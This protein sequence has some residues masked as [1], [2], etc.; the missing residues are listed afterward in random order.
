MSERILITGGAGFIGRIVGRELLDRGYE[1]RVLDSLIEQ[2][3]G[4]GERPEGLDD[5][6]LLVGD[7]CDASC[8]R[9]ALANVDAVIHLAAEVGVGQSMYAITRYTA[10]N[11][12][13]TATLFEQLLEQPVRRV[14][15]ASSMR[16]Y[17]EGLYRSADG[18]LFEDV[19]RQ[20]T[21]G[22]SWDP[23]DEEGR[24]LTPLQTPES[25]RHALA[26][27]AA[28]R[29]GTARVAGSSRWPAEH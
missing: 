7:I 16:I 21:T 19:Q 4:G 9:R 24:P 20:R 18:R 25:K 29:V 26:H 23:V 1:V 12:L 15:T 28:R 6:E 5:M 2:V 27:S 17:G 14:V 22:G 11:E 8:V 3:H 13:G 10:T